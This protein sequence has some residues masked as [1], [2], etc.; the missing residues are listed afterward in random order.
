MTTVQE[1]DLHADV[2]DHAPAQVG[3]AQPNVQ[4]PGE[5]AGSDAGTPV[6][7]GVPMTWRMGA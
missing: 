4:D 5:E 2:D 7:A 6:F 1:R 3:A